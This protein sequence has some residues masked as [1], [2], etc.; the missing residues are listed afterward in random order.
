MTP[1]EYLSPASALQSA[2]LV[3]AGLQYKLQA[4]TS[5]R[6]AVPATEFL[7]LFTHLSPPQPLEFEKK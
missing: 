3:S 1:A 2:V 6:T 7:T 5:R 4:E